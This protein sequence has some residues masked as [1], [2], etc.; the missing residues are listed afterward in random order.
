[1]YLEY[2]LDVKDNKSKLLKYLSHDSL[3]QKHFFDKSGLT[4]FHWA[5]D[6]SSVNYISDMCL[7]NNEENN[8]LT[9][10]KESLDSLKDIPVWVMSNFGYKKTTLYHVYDYY[11]DPRIKHF[12]NDFNQLEISL[13]GE[14]GPYSL[15]NSMNWF[16]ENIY[17]Q[18]MYL[19]IIECWR[20]KRNFRMGLTIPVKLSKVQCPLFKAKA[21]IHQVTMHGLVMKVET[22]LLSHFVYD[23]DIFVEKEHSFSPPLLASPSRDVLSGERWWDAI[24]DFTI[25]GKI[26]SDLVRDTL[27]KD[28]RHNSYIFISAALLKESDFVF[29]KAECL[30]EESEYLI[31]KVAA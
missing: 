29:D 16:D 12:W 4:Y 13:S 23:Q 28:K 9:Q 3:S 20:P 7:N 26:F 15:L 11:S 17:A 14:I 19:K 22:S 6:I 5:N 24:G 8:R 27:Q 10:L 18:F 25:N 31:K 30:L 1:M 21:T 2:A